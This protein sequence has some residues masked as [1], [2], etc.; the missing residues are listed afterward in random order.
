MRRL[1]LLVLLLSSVTILFGLQGISHVEES[2]ISI[3]RVEPNPVTE[4]NV[5]EYL[6]LAAPAGTNLDGYVLSDGT[7][8]AALPNR[9]VSGQIAVTAQPRVT[10]LLTDETVLGW[11]GYL[12]LAADGDTIRLIRP[13]G[14]TA[15][16][17]RY[18]RTGDSEGWERSEDGSIGQTDDGIAVG[19]FPERTVETGTAFVLP[20]APDIVAETIADAEDRLWIAGYELTDP[21]ITRL[22]TD[23]FA[24]GVDVRVLVDGRPVGGQSDAEL[25]ALDRVRA[26]GVPV[27]VLDGDRRRYRYHH[28]K[29]AI[30]DDTAI[31]TSENW[32][33]AGTGGA[34]SR[35]WGIAIADE[36]VAADLS[37]VF[38]TD[39]E[40]RD[41]VSWSRHGET[42]PVQAGNRTSPLP[43][44]NHPPRTIPI[45]RAE[46]VVAPADAMERMHDLI[47]DAEHRIDI[48]Q[49]R[50]GDPDFPLLQ[51]AIDAAQRG[52]HVRIQLD[53]TWYVADENAAM[54]A[55]L[56]SLAAESDYD[57]DIAKMEP[58]DRFEKIHNKGMIVDG[59]TVVVGSMNWNNVSALENREVS[60]IVE[61]DAVADYYTAVF[62]DDWAPPGGETPIGFVA[63]VVGIW[64]GGGFL[65]YR[66]V[67]FDPN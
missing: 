61:G 25:A 36:D 40:W 4:G 58:V 8:T 47:R 37:R 29:Y 27:Y 12:P 64:I 6:V 34:S 53:S 52:V 18:D 33:P 28:P 65:A 30:A 39:L 54:V 13:D 22:I 10:A 45:D 1:L 50:I 3:Q 9:T 24:A 21:T 2:D 38:E 55:H 46:L 60:L 26:A 11:D 49:V 66:R 23:R 19:P 63:A 16:E 56:E 35:G 7:Y 43:V 31:V 42:G 62:E 57:L 51:A 20:D 41:R 5:G 14:Q 59:E 48:Q 44:D 15:D 67:S 32:K 17:F